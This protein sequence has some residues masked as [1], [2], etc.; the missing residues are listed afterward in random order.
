VSPRQVLNARGIVELGPFRAQ[1]RDHV[2]LAA[3]LE[4]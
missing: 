4:P 3:N 1:R 2:A